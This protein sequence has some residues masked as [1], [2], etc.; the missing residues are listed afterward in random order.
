MYIYIKAK[1]LSFLVQY[2]PSTTNDDYHHLYLVYITIQ[3]GKTQNEHIFLSSF[4]T[5]HDDA[6]RPLH[7]FIC[8]PQADEMK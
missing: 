2:V 3:E 8:V 7:V 1:A 6:H 5:I 4:F